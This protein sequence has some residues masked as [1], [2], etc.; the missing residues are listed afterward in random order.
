MKWVSVEYST[1][2]PL[3]PTA[4]C[5]LWVGAQM[6]AKTAFMASADPEKAGCSVTARPPTGGSW[7][8]HHVFLYLWLSA[9]AWHTVGPYKGG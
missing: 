9:Q 2:S 7:R 3:P 4:C 8:N 6:Q 1:P 5:H